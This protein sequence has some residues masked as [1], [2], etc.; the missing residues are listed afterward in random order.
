MSQITFENVKVGDGPSV[1]RI[2][3][4][5]QLVQYA[6]ASGDYT[7]IHYDKD[8]AQNAGHERVILHGALKSSMLAEMLY[9]WI[10]ENGMITRLETSYRAVD[11]P[12]VP[13][14]LS[15]TITKKYVDDRSGFLDLDIEI[16][17]QDG[18]VTTPGK[19]TVSLPLN[20]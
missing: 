12:E 15:G 19:A 4:T 16:R 5:R 3:T 11:Y 13:L 9:D 14:T 8:Y 20:N 1:T 17:N 10:G 7:P 2:A 18:T 6:A